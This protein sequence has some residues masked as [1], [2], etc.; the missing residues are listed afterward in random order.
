MD[1]NEKIRVQTPF[2]STE[3]TEE[4]IKNIS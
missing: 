3:E 4:I 1:T 2:I